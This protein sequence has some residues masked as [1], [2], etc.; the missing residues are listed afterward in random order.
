MKAA[1][2]VILA[3][4]PA[5]ADQASCAAGFKADYT[6]EWQM[7]GAAWN[8]ACSKG[9][10]AGDVLRQAQRDS[11]SRCVAKFLP[12]EQKGKIPLGQTQAFCAQ[13]S[14][15]RAS[16]AN[17]AGVPLD[18][19]PSAPK[20][21]AGPR[22]PERKPGSSGMGP[23]TEALGKA[24][25][26]WKPDACFSGLS[27]YFSEHPFS[28][29]E[30]LESARL[31]KRPT[32]ITDRPGTDYFNYYFASEQA[33]R[34]IYRVSYREE[35]KHCPDTLRFASPRHENAPRPA[36]LDSCLGDI[37]VDVGQAVE[38]AARNG[39]KVAAPVRA[40]LANFPKGFFSKTCGKSTAALGGKVWHAYQVECGNG[41][42]DLGGLRL[43]AG[44][45]VWV[46]STSA[47]T[48]VVD[49]STGRFRFLGKGEFD[50]DAP[51]DVGA[52]G[53][54]LKAQ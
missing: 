21:A 1:L 53:M 38:I 35:L 29:C 8:A 34:D 28:S 44:T 51:I 24:R 11:M 49:A 37:S 41:G 22:I 47:Q 52:G 30:E 5:D 9:L 36:G 12:Y 16:L 13:G 33:E 3:A 17:A 54:T 10:D 19:P 26:A 25:S 42:W 48:A 50:M 6:R 18:A 39:W 7:T 14:E 23:L 46:L 4:S 20:P 43:A 2:L 27:Y 45:P 40:F 32:R 15:G 31:E